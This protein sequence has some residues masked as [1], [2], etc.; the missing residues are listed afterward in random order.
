MSDY[1]SIPGM[2]P[3]QGTYS[4]LR[5]Q[6]AGQALIGLL[7]QHETQECESGAR[8][9]WPVYMFGA[10]HDTVVKRA[11]DLADAM[12]AEAKRRSQQNTGV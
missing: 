8:D 9:L 7:S 3:L 10:G 2:P 6:Y 5:D 4:A 11:F 12:V 1:P